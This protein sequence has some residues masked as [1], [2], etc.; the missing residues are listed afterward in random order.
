MSKKVG[1]IDTTTILLVGG[2]LLAAYLLMRP[3]VQPTPIIT[4]PAGSTGTSTTNTAITAGASV[5]DSFLN[6][7]NS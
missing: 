5:I 4:L 6:Y 1:A 3:R 7:L 2:G